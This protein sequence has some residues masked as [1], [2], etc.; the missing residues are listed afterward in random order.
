LGSLAPDLHLLFPHSHAGPTDVILTNEFTATVLKGDPDRPYGIAEA[1][2][3]AQ[4][5]G[6]ILDQLV[7]L[8]GGKR[9]SESRETGI[10]F[11]C[12][13]AWVSLFA[14]KFSLLW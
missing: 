3:R 5:P 2:S 4:T 9:C 14:R 6:A 13:G 11:A 10:R 1:P 8:E 12:Y 7:E